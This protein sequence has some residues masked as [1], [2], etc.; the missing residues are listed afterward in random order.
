MD[1]LRPTTVAETLSALRR[2][3]G[4]ATLIAGGTDLIAD[5]KFRGFQP[6]ALININQVEGLRYIEEDARVSGSAA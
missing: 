3:G 2:L 6:T 1:Y 4:T 5:M